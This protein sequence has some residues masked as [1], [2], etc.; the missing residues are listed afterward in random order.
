MP[1]TALCVCVF[2]LLELLPQTNRKKRKQIQGTHWDVRKLI[3]VT[4]PEFF[5]HPPS[6]P[7]LGGCIH[8]RIQGHTHTPGLQL[9]KRDNSI[10]G[11]T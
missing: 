1:V 9:Y 2:S 5:C 11:N 6:S 8:R 3:L 4:K 10:S 7:L